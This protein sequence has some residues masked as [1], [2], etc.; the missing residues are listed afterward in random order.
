MFNTEFLNEIRLFEIE[1]L[2]EHLEPARKV[3][4]IGG[5]TGIQACQLSRWG[6]QVSSIDVAQS[7]YAFE[8]VFPVTDYDGEN[9]PFP[10]EAFDVVFSSN[11]LEHVPDLKKMHQEIQRVLRPGGHC[12]HVMPSCAWRSWHTAAYHLDYA[13]RLATLLRE[14]WQE[15]LSQR[16][17]WRALRGPLRAL[18]HAVLNCIPGR[19][20]H[21]GNFL[22]EQ[23]TFRRAWWTAHF[24]KHG[25]EVLLA[26][27]VGPF[28]TGHMILGDR[29]P[30]PSRDRWACRLGRACVVYKVRPAARP[31]GATQGPVGQA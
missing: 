1:R 8:R 2:R 22:T 10:S 25:F 13:R 6:Y 9:I 17:P 31:C 14:N 28:Y 19:H 7:T 27:P 29:W 30:V 16:D 5:G 18:K 12:V 3:L 24:Q 21:T 11:T 4:E 15:G 23:W 20:G 26:A